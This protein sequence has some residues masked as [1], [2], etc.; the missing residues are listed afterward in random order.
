MYGTQLFPFQV[1]P[2][3]ETICRRDTTVPVRAELSRVYTDFHN[4]V[5]INRHSTSK[6]RDT[7]Q[8]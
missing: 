4:G 1:L 8:A 2:K 5:V 3:R 6:S 7:V